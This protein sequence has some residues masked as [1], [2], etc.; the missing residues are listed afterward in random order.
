MFCENCGKQIPDSTRF[1]PFCGMQV[2]DI[3]NDPAGTVSGPEP[4][5]APAQTPPPAPEPLYQQQG[6]QNA[7]QGYEHQPYRQGWQNA[8]QN[9]A[10]QP[11]QQPWNAT[12]VAAYGQQPKKSN[13]KVIIIIIAAVLAVAGLAVG[14]YFL[15]FRGEMGNDGS[16]GTPGSAYAPGSSLAADDQTAA[17][18][19]TSGVIVPPQPTE[20]LTDP[21]PEPTAEAPT[22]PPAP[23]APTEPVQVTD[24]YSMPERGDF[25]WFFDY[26]YGNLPDDI[27]NMPDLQVL[28]GRWKAFIVYVDG[29][30]TAE[31]YDVVREELC[32]GEIT[33]AGTEFSMKVDPIS[34]LYDDQLGWQSVTGVSYD[35]SGSFQQDGTVYMVGSI[36]AVTLNRFFYSAGCQ[37]VVGYIVLPSGEEAYIGLTRP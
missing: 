13:S 7:T 27:V 21:G 28:S 18:Q 34:E 22:D 3:E 14:A 10:Q 5:P 15:F 12:P 36:G 9:Y 32:V 26:S 1:C 30:E 4:A 29:E 16:D 37:R 25:D 6:W 35:C 23:T 33:A 31:Y 11:Y 20:P 2:L 24:I 8:P 19:S 17:D